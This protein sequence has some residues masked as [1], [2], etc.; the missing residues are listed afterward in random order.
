MTNSDKITNAS[1]TLELF[2]GYTVEMC[3]LTL[4][5]MADLDAYVRGKFIK[6]TLTAIESLDAESQDKI[7]QNVAL[8][9]QQM[10]WADR[11][12]T[13]I[14]ETEVDG[15][16]YY[17]YKYVEK[18][19]HDD[20]N[21]WKEL[22]NAHREENAKL[23]YTTRYALYFSD[24]HTPNAGENEDRDPE[25]IYK[26]VDAALKAGL[27]LNTILELTP[28]QIAMMIGDREKITAA[29]DGKLHFRDADEFRAWRE[30]RKKETAS[31]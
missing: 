14:F 30:A 2:D 27:A 21:S 22:F 3:R 1:I 7:I 18:A 11:A 8:A 9:A 6:N 24:I 15:L 17:A 20:F 5:Q 26:L 4:K 19:Y 23:F 10:V 13:V 25:A 12:A 16:A 31:V 29:N 28:D